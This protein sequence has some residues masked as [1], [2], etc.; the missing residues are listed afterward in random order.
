M[1]DDAETTA[2]LVKVSTSLEFF[3]NAVRDLSVKIDGVEET[4]REET[5]E[6]YRRIDDHARESRAAFDAMREETH[7]A[8]GRVERE[9][10]GFGTNLEHHAALD[11]TRFDRV[12]KAISESSD[13]RGKLWR[14]VAGMT[15]ASGIGAALAKFFG[16][17]SAP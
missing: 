6:V 15:G 16:G 3:G 2:A 11:E 12:E 4:A 17:G 8:I 5:R 1:S 9:L 14:T 7:V 13:D 10:T